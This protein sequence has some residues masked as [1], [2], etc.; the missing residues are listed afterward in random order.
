MY[1]APPL[2]ASCEEARRARLNI[3]IMADQPNT[4]TVPSIEIVMIE[5]VANLAFVAHGLLDVAATDGEETRR[6]D[7][8]EIAIDI[9]G[10]AY[11][12]ISARLSGD[13]RAEIARMLTELRLSYV[14][15]RGT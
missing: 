10:R 6:L 7:D 8:A 12:R 1:Y 9:A 15:K 3:E 2:N 4:T 14:K 5:V 13:E 11:D